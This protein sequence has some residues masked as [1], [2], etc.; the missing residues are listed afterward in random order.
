M[1]IDDLKRKLQPVF[2]EHKIQKA[3]LFGSLARGEASRHS[4]ID[5]I[6]V[7]NTN[8]RFLDRYDGVLLAFSQALPEWDVDLLIYTPA[9][10]ERISGRRFIQQALKEGLACL[11]QSESLYEAKRW[12]LTAKSLHKTKKFSHAGFLSQQSAEKALWLA[13]DSDPWGHSIQN[14]TPSQVYHSKDSAQAI[15][16]AGFFLEK[17]RKLLENLQQEQ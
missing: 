10:L 14:L 2:K 9:E 13:V 1:K 12:R 4:D 8:R 6:L 3:I 16:R 5:M 17:T 11:S 7:K 15:E